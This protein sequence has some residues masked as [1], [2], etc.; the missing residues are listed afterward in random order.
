MEICAICQNEID[1]KKS[2]LTSCNHHFCSSCFFKWLEKK[3]D[4]PVCRKVFKKNTNYD[5]EIER[6]ILDQLEGEVRDYT[7]LVDEL[8]EQAFNIE[9]KKNAM[10]KICMDMDEAI[11]GKKEEFIKVNNDLID[12][13]RRRQAMNENIQNRVRYLNNLENKRIQNSRN[14]NRKFGLNLAG[15]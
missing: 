5:I 10:I 9:Y 4:C 11:K 8:R 7:N 13:D 12:L 6:E 14:R 3:A 1:F 15:R 2:V